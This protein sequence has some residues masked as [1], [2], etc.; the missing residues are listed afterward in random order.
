MRS[1]K[2]GLGLVSGVLVAVLAAPAAA[3]IGTLTEKDVGLPLVSKPHPSTVI[4]YDTV[5]PGTCEPDEEV[6]HE[7]VVVSFGTKG[8]AALNEIV[9]EFASAKE[10]ASFFDTARDADQ[11]RADCGETENAVIVEM[12][13]WP[14]GL[15]D[16]R[17][18]FTSIEEVD[19]VERETVAVHLR[20]DRRIVVVNF[21]DWSKKQPGMKK[22]LKAALAHLG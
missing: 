15:G 20:S 4:A 18:S 9:F 19:G 11:A 10:A 7:A 3:G 14:K 5:V 16:D 21:L 6:E 17:Y 13:A 22:V 1:W 2:P 8:G 12:R